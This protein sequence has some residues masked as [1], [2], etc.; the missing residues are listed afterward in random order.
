MDTLPVDF[1]EYDKNTPI[2]T[3]VQE[4][5]DKQLWFFNIEQKEREAFI[6]KQDN[7][8]I[9]ESN[10]KTKKKTF[11]TEDLAQEYITKNNLLKTK[12]EKDVFTYFTAQDDKGVFINYN[13]GMPIEFKKEEVALRTALFY[14][15]DLVKIR[16]SFSQYK[17][18]VSKEELK[19]V[20]PF[21]KSSGKKE[22][23]KFLEEK[24]SVS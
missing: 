22:H 6:I 15:M 10:D 1:F 3:V 13:N 14:N 19:F 16:L 21:G 2:E 20:L 11:T 9:M 23:V 18:K 24:S 4:W 12:V 5:K 7:E 17:E 8:V